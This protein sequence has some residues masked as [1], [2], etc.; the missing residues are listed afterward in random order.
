M[1]PQNPSAICLVDIAIDAGP[2]QTMHSAQQQ[3]PIIIY[4]ICGLV[5]WDTNLMDSRFSV[6]RVPF[7]R[8][9]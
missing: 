6:S 3:V 9:Y 1:R 2:A 4:S 8:S 7:S 5:D